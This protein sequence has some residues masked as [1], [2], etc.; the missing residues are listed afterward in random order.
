MRKLEL[1]PARETGC[2]SGAGG[3]SDSSSQTVKRVLVIGK[4]GER[5]GNLLY[6]LRDMGID[7][8][9]VESAAECATFLRQSRSIGTRIDA[10][11]A[12]QPSNGSTS[13]QCSIEHS[14][15][16]NIP[17]VLFNNDGGKAA[18]STEPYAHA[19]SGGV[20]ATIADLLRL[21][22]GPA[23][24]IPSRP[25]ADRRDVAANSSADI[26]V[27][28]DN[29][30]NQ[31]V[32]SQYLDTTPYSYKIVINGRRAVHAFRNISP[33]L[34]L[35]DLSMPEMN[36]KEATAAIR[37]LEGE[38]GQRVPII[39]LTAHAL[40][41]DR[42]DCLASG[43]DGYISKPIDFG[44]LGDILSQNL[45]CGSTQAVDAA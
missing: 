18:D 29:D 7:C 42:E 35:M 19:K 31:L 1:K 10:I 14:G 26:L 3:M 44:L 22:A 15:M 23:T 28:E 37:A 33:R 8:A 43:M 34:I 2:I 9:A 30:I 40:K 20:L 11:V 36:G 38:D 39:A 13:F 16:E 27:A 32:I 41:G 6:G 45:G 17:V 21:H 24:K 4:N 5:I 12:E 25:F